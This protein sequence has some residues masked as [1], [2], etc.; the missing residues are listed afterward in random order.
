MSPFEG[1]RSS[2]ASVESTYVPTGGYRTRLLRAGNENKETVLLLHGAGPGVNVWF[3]WASAVPFFGQFYNCV[4]PDLLGF[5]RTDHPDSPYQLEDWVESRAE[6]VLLLLEA[7]GIGKANL[8]GQ[9]SGG[10]RV[11]LRLLERSPERLNRVVIMGAAGMKTSQDGGESNSAGPPAKFYDHPSEDAMARIIRGFVHNQRT[12]ES[13]LE[14]MAKERFEEAMR[15]EIRRSFEAMSAMSPQEWT[16]SES[17]LGRVTNDVLLLHGR[18]DKMVPAKSSVHLMRKLPNARLYVFPKCGH[19]VQ[20]DQRDGFH[21]L[22]RSF[23]SGE[24]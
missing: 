21:H 9:S 7:L 10:G 17:V 16:I 8:V 11:A 14:K 22:V 15:P 23:L 20:L 6:Q 24:I 4:A 18:E 19:W 12:L 2:T 13:V 1:I 3:N 5:G